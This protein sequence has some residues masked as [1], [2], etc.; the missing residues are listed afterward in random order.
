MKFVGYNRGDFIFKDGTAIKGVNV[1]IMTEIDKTRGDGFA[2]ER[3]YLTDAKLER[4]NID[5]A[6]LLNREVMVYYNRYGKA[7]KI[8]AVD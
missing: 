8:V 7:E 4:G 6:S 3:I 2:V 1:Y 5:L